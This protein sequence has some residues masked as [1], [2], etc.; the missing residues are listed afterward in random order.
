MALTEGDNRV[1]WASIGD[2]FS[3]LLVG[4]RA[5]RQHDS[6]LVQDVP[7]TSSRLSSP[8]RTSTDTVCHQHGDPIEAHKEDQSR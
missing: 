6:L 5:I 7:L 2:T 3:S 8:L 1:V 4:I